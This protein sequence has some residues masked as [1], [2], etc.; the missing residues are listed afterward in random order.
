M[1]LACSRSVSGHGSLLSLHAVLLVTFPAVAVL[2]DMLAVVAGGCTRTPAASLNGTRGPGPSEPL[3][4]TPL[5]ET[6]LSIFVFT[7]VRQMIVFN[8]CPGEKTVGEYLLSI[9]FP[10]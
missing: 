7:G 2:A 4:Q 6:A 10:N 5:A 8:L 1:L 3:G 9:P